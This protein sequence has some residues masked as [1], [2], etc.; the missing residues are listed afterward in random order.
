MPIQLKCYANLD[1]FQPKNGDAFDILPGETVGALEVRLGI[2]EGEVTLRFVNGR[3]VEPDA[4]LQD[5]DRVG[6][7][8]PVGGG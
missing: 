5:G 8:P 2:P 6:L 3:A 1:T 7:F 4:V